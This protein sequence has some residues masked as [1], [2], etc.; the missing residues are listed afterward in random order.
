MVPTIHDHGSQRISHGHVWYLVA[1]TAAEL[2]EEIF[3]RDVAEELIQ[4]SNLRP[5]ESQV[6][7]EMSLALSMPQR[8]SENM[9][10]SDRILP[11]RGKSSY[12]PILQ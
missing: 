2:V 12:T 8:C 5:L 1:A 9:Y 7:S 11:E 4:E 6:A 10:D 3:R